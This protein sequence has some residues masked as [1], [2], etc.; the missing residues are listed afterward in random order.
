MRNSKYLQ[1]NLTKHWTMTCM[2]L[3]E[4][5]V[6]DQEIVEKF[7]NRYTSACHSR[8][9]AQRKTTDKDD[10]DRLPPCPCLPKTL[11]KFRF[12]IFVGFFLFVILVFV[13]CLSFLGDGREF[14]CVA[15]GFLIFCI[16]TVID[17]SPFWWLAY[18]FNFQPTME[19]IW[20]SNRA[21]QENRCRLTMKSSR[22]K[23]P[24]SSS[25]LM[26][27]P[28]TILCPELKKMQNV[29]A[30]FFCLQRRRSL[31]I[32]QRKGR[33]VQL[34][35]KPALTWIQEGGGHPRIAHRDGAWQS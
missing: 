32:S 30:F 22:T 3:V 28:P 35:T 11:S 18:W 8:D 29:F 5:F 26:F 24:N 4:L 31:K 17:T 14:F 25:V 15:V 10:A 13:S 12:C 2:F 33:A 1:P 20:T 7:Y 27:S 21:Q 34:S 16:V 9:D 6:A 23:T 19:P